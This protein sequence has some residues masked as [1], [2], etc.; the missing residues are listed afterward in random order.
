[1]EITVQTGVPFAYDNG[2][3]AI[4]AATHTLAFTLDEGG[5]VAQS[6]VVLLGR[7]PMAGGRPLLGRFSFAYAWSRE[8]GV[9]TVN[10]TD[11]DDPGTMC[12]TT[13]PEGSM[14]RCRQRASG[15]GFREEDLKANTVWNYTTPLTPGVE[16]LLAGLARG[17]NDAVIQALQAQPGIV[18]QVR[19]PVPKLSPELH[20]KLLFVYR[21]GVF[22]RAYLAGAPVAA[23]EQVLTVESVFGGEVTLNYAEAFANVIGSTS[24]PKIAGLSWI[25]LW[26]NQYGQYPVICTSYHSNGFGCG[27]TL[28]GGHVIGGTVAKSMP[29]GSNAVW[30][31]PICIQHNNDDHVYMQA[32]KYLKGIWLKNYLGT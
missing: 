1:M 17:A 19:K 29:K 4:E 10:G 26:A 3:V 7:V 20:A 32:L 9:V 8:T 31:F 6:Q 25:Q 21:D 15:G 28:V 24:D 30:I 23:D 22:D 16:E 2:F 12:L 27:N 5:S 14:E 13:W 11:F 18:V